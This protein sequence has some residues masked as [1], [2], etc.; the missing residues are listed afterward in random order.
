MVSDI[1]F[2]LPNSTNVPMMSI[3]HEC[4]Y[5]STENL[6]CCQK[7]ETLEFS[8]LFST[9]YLDGIEMAPARHGRTL[10]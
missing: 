3:C 10:F 8:F 5:I 2:V 6:L 7:N 4:T 9:M 1:F